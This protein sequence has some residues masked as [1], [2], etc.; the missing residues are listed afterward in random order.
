MNYDVSKLARLFQTEQPVWPRNLRLQ[1]FQETSF[2]L[3]ARSIVEDD[4]LL[5]SLGKERPRPQSPRSVGG[6]GHKPLFLVLSC[7]VYVSGSRHN[8]TT[9]K[10]TV[11]AKCCAAEGLGSA[12]STKLHGH[13]PQKLHCV[14]CGKG[15]SVD[16]N[17][18]DENRVTDFDRRLITTAQKA[19]NDD[20]A[21]DVR[22]RNFIQLYEI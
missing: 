16:Y 2:R 17:P 12:H 22:H 8:Q 7:S 15:Y 5:C 1:R 4:A 14:T 10:N 6:K 13:H 9:M 21:R 18:A 11:D 20:H 19:I 3:G